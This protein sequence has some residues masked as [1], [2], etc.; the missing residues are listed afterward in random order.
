MSDLPM[1]FNFN[2]YEFLTQHTGQWEKIIALVNSQDDIGVFLRVHL[3][4]EQA[5]E[6]WCIC[7][8]GNG[9]FFNGFGENVSMDFAAKAQLAKNFGLSE[10][11]TKFVKK[12]NRFRN[13]RSHQIE[14]PN[15]EQSEIDS[16]TSL[17]RS[18]YPEELFPIDQFGL[19]VP[20]SRVVKFN[21]S[22]ASLRDKLIMLYSMLAM[23]MSY[24]AK[25]KR[26]TQNHNQ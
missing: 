26:Q 22:H 23:R 3:L 24:E 20:G 17:I 2:H 13:K 7:A 4:I 25:S 15:I 5:I 21:D 1:T 18:E 11:V 19:E 6:A 12:L 8:S 16:L 9:S 14:H 10:P